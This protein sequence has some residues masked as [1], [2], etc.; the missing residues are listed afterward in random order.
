MNFAAR[1]VRKNFWRGNSA[2][3]GIGATQKLPKQSWEITKNLQPAVIIEEGRLRRWFCAV[4]EEVGYRGGSY[5]AGGRIIGDNAV[6]V[7]RGC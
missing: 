2:A 1:G 7:R 4:K 5:G 6:C 3:R